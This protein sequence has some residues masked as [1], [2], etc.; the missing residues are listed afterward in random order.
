MADHIIDGRVTGRQQ[1]LHLLRDACAGA[2][3]L[4]EQHVIASGHW[5]ER[6]APAVKAC[7]VLQRGLIQSHPQLADQLHILAT[8][9]QIALAA[10]SDDALFAARVARIRDA[11]RQLQQMGATF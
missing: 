11:V 7:V 2:S 5:P 8:E 1:L 6:A 9:I 3:A 10:Q 4:C